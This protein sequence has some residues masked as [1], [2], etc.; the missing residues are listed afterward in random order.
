ML[1]GGDGRAHAAPCRRETRAPVEGRVSCA[2]VRDG[3]R[4][5]MGQD[6]QR[7][8]LALRLRQARQSGLAPWVIPQ[9]Q[10]RGCSEGPCE[11]GVADGRARRA[12]ALAGGCLG[13]RDHATRGDERLH[14]GDA[15]QGVARIAQ[16]QSQEL[17]DAGHGWPPVAGGRVMRCG[18]LHTGARERPE[19]L[20]VGVKP[21]EVDCETL[22]HRGSGTPLRDPSPMALIGKRLADRG[23]VV[24]AGRLLDV[25]QQRGA[26]AS[27]GHPAPQ[28]VPGRA[29]L[30]G[31]DRGLWEPAAAA[32]HRHLVGVDP[33][34]LGRAPMQGVHGQGRAQDEGKTLLGATVG[35]P[36]PR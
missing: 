20:L 28:Q 13:T 18:R 36:G 3:T 1:Q 35:E 34:V 29:P 17:A 6:G 10:P 33:I 4:Q 19:L 12:R 8:A 14:P 16:H 11:G 23:P 26:L 9:A 24:L 15:L 25:G 31:I 2:Q 30:G 22:V 5:R 21:R 7:R 27:P 32:P